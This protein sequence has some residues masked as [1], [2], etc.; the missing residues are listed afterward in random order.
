MPIALIILGFG[1]SAKFLRRIK[2]KIKG[3]VPNTSRTNA[4]VATEI[5]VEALNSLQLI[6]ESVVAEASPT[7]RTLWSKY[8]R[9]AL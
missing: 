9:N 5:K 6:R 2:P 8:L 4:A 3:L 1:R 7:L